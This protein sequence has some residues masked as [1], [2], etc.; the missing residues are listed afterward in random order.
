LA[1][2]ATK[3]FVKSAPYGVEKMNEGTENKIIVVTSKVL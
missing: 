1:K 2:N 3:N